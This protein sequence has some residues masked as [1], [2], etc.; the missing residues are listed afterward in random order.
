MRFD[1]PGRRCNDHF[2][3]RRFRPAA[4]A[5]CRE[6]ISDLADTVR[7]KTQ[8]ARRAVGF[9]PP[10]STV[11]A[12][13][14]L[15]CRHDEATAESPCRLMADS[16]RHARIQTTWWTCCLHDLRLERRPGHSFLRPAKSPIEKRAGARPLLRVSVSPAGSPDCCRA[17]TE[18]FDPT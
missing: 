8:S 1:R 17:W 6:A 7:N 12:R 14:E 4:A 18:A 16:T 11:V 10:D 9:R 3:W 5:V 13:S 15:R 2:G